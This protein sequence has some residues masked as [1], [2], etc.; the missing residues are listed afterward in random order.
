MTL[1]FEL[2]KPQ[3][4]LAKARREESRL[5]DAILSQ[6]RTRIADALFNFAVTAYHVKDWLKESASGYLPKDVESYVHGDRRLRMCREICNASKHRKLNHSAADTGNVTAS[7]TSATSPLLPSAAKPAGVSLE[8]ESKPHFLVKIVAVDG[9]RFEVID[10]AAQVI[11][12]WE[13]FF[14]DHGLSLR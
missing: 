4:L 1:T 8:T 7:A 6:N 2:D 10:F 9:T 3:D 13:Q 14:N 5:R 12:A 11:G